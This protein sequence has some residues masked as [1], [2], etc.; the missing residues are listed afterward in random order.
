MRTKTS[1]LLAALAA[2]VAL[3]TGAAEQTTH[4][5]EVIL[6]RIRALEQE[7]QSLKQTV[8]TQQT[9]AKEDTKVEELDQKIRVLE[10]KQE[11]EQ[12]Q[13]AAKAK[14]T[15][16]LSV[17][18]KG[19]SLQSGDG[20]FNLRLRSLVQADSRFYFDNGGVRNND[21]FLIRR[22][23]IE[24]TGTLFD[25]LDFRIMPDFAGTTP[26]LLDAWLDWKI[27]PYFQVLAGKVKLPVGL[28]RF[29]SRENNLLTE[30][31]YPTSLV[32]NRDIGI[33]LHGQVLNGALDYYVGAFNGTRDG[34]STVVDSE[35]DKSVAAWLFA[36]PFAKSDNAALKGLG[37]G[38]A[39]TYG[40][41]E[42]TPSNFNTVGQQA[43]YRWRTG[44]ANDGTTWRIVP[45]AYYFYG[46]FGLLGEYAISSQKVRSGTTLGTIQNQAWEVTASY[47]LTGEDA[48]FRGVKPAKSVSFG[49]K[50]GWGAWQLVARVTELDIDDDAFPTFANPATSASRARSYGGGINWY[51]NQQV[52]IS[53]DYNWTAL[54]GAALRDE[55]A[56]ITRVQFRY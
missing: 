29:Q 54:S 16:I 13:A 7:L 56:L 48:T 18:E 49:E 46:P 38:I 52:R 1:A 27:S 41:D 35:D 40:N 12:E 43:F 8:K 24:L 4:G 11:I 21:T 10:R 39:G 31:G 15:P 19:F 45:Q 5:D 37:F 17:G 9:S 50:R 2:A 51:L 6:S 34:G 36:T 14:T 26:T 53:A 33:A 23:R 42:G 55:H 28:E 44:V 47:V 22:A 32:P 20:A 30:F 3:N 25:K